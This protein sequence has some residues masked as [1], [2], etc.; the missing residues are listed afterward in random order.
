MK[1]QNAKM[2]DFIISHEVNK[3][4]NIFKN[5]FKYQTLLRTQSLDIFKDSI[6]DT[7][8]DPSIIRYKIKYF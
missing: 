3:I 8:K 5:I 7:F 2:L 6:L 1:W 4:L